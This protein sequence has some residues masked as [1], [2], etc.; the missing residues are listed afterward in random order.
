MG[1]RNVVISVHDDNSGTF[2]YLSENWYLTGD[3][4]NQLMSSL[5]LMFTSEAHLQLHNTDCYKVLQSDPTINTQNKIPTFLKSGPC[6]GLIDNESR[7]YLLVT[8]R[9]LIFIFLVYDSFLSLS[10]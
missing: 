1:F 6:K 10:T 9:L 8:L 4:H 3:I 2:I 5:T 7:S